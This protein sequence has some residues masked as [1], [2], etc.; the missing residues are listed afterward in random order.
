MGE[1]IVVVVSCID[2]RL[3]G[4]LGGGNFI[5]EFARERG[6]HYFP[7][8]SAGGVLDIV[9]PRG[10]GYDGHMLENI[11]TGL[12]NGAD[13]IILMN[14]EGCHAYKAPSL[15][16]ERKRHADDLPEAQH[17]IDVRFPDVPSSLFMACFKNGSRDHFVP[18][19][20]EDFCAMHA[21]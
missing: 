18:F 14:H 21:L 6:F 1:K 17:I 19:S 13:R 11:E 9:R 16:E 4:K 2:Q 5:A 8:L 10:I 7:A 12:S 15:E 3:H 20:F